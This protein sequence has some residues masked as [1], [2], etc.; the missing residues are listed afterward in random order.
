MNRQSDAPPLLSVILACLLLLP[1]ALN[2][3]SLTNR[4]R[5]SGEDLSTSFRGA[6]LSADQAVE[7]RLHSLK[8]SGVNAIVLLLRG[9]D[10]REA[11]Q[12]ASELVRRSGLALHYWV[13]VAH[14]RELADAHPDWMASLQ[15][16]TEW[17]RLF[18]DV[19]HPGDGEVVKTYPWVPILSKEPFDAQLQRIEE[20]L[21]DRPQPAGVF[22]ND[23][24]GAPSA[25]GC[26][27]H[28]CRWTSDYG[29]LRTTMPL[30]NDAPAEFVA[31]IR[32]LLPEAEVIPV[33]TTECEE[34][35]GAAN[36]LC[37][38]VG[39][40]KGICWKAWTEQLVPVARHSETLGVLLPYRAFQRDLPIYEEPA[41]WIAEALNSFQD[42]PARYR[43]AGVPAS[44]LLAV[45]QGWN[46]ADRQIAQQV[47]AAA[48]SGAAG[49]IIAYTEIEQGWKPQ[50]LKMK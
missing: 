34:H 8:S 50:I 45:L 32:K 15:G 1:F 10:Q 24:Q 26:G 4:I 37:A 46:V 18:S 20:L 30:T 41:G 7:G 21:A 43:E 38:G 31:A 3:V 44:R 2:A 39:C 6:L 35:D 22:L 28:L 33:W 19:P 12:R 36:G 9:G 5:Q 11:E 16:H 17:R 13:E 23:L 47:T 14:C 42:M 48:E 27:N 29:K 49:H 40:F 25:C